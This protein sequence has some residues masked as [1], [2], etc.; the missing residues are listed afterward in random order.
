M[1]RGREGEEEEEES[2]L[3]VKKS[4]VEAVEEWGDVGFGPSNRAAEAV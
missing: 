4:K 1:H 3:E 2:R